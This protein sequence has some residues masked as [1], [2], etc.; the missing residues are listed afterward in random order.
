MQVVMFKRGI[1]LCAFL[2]NRA[3]SFTEFC[4]RLYERGVNIRAMNLHSDNEV[5]I[6]RMVVDDTQMAITVLRDEQIPFLQTEVLVVE[7]PNQQGMA[8]GVGHRLTEASIDIEY[9]YFS[10][11]QS[12]APALM[13]FKVSDLEAAL[14]RLKNSSRTY[15]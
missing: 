9:T 6:L 15:N 12:E 13:V 5:G 3:G 8:A 14:T 2:E 10:S 7:V 11:G 1:Q 4:E